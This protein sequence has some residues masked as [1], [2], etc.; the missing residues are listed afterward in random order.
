MIDPDKVR[1][2][3]DE[4]ERLAQ[5]TPAEQLRVLALIRGPAED[6]KVPKA[7]RDAACERYGALKRLLRAARPQP[8][9]PA[10]K[11]PKRQQ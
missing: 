11:R 4:A 9:R 7:D 2:Y 6:P 5:L 8:A 3:R 10:R 1:E